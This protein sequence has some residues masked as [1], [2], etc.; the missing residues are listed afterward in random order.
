MDLAAKVEELIKLTTSLKKEISDMKGN[1]VNVKVDE[2]EK[3]MGDLKNEI[4]ELKYGLMK[5]NAKI[6]AIIHELSETK[7]MQF[8]E[9]IANRSETATDTS[10]SAPRPDIIQRNVINFSKYFPIETFKDLDKLESLLSNG[11]NN[12]EVLLILQRLLL[13]NGVAKNLK[14]VLSAN[15]IGQSNLEGIHGKIRLLKYKRFID[16][17]FQAVYKDG[18]NLKAFLDDMRTGMR[19]VK[20]RNSKLKARRLLEESQTE[21][22]NDDSNNHDNDDNY[23][24][25]E[26][27]EDEDQ[28]NSELETIITTEGNELEEVIRGEDSQ[29]ETVIKTEDAYIM[30][31]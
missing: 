14:Y 3:E 27:M 10:S 24:V 23:D 4:N 11:S 17:L 31:D 8:L 30:G 9:N 7:K 21:K 13:P 15:I 2:L 16:T 29:L 12:Q 20:N 6:L 18:Y 19:L 5:Q 26:D 1:D 22:H 25:D 28:L